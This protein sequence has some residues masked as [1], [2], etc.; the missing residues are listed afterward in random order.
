MSAPLPNYRFSYLIA[1]RPS[2]PADCQ[3]FGRQLLDALEKNDAE[4]LA[5]LRATQEIRRS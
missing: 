3:A 5:L 2:W 4:G 1:R